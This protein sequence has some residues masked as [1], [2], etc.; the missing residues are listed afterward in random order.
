[1]KAGCGRSKSI[2]ARTGRDTAWSATEPA[3]RCRNLRPGNLI[4]CPPRDTKGIPNSGASNI[5]RNFPLMTR[6]S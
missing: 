1:M 4:G 3:A 2:C 5:G 6:A